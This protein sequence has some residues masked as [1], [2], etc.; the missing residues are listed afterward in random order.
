MSMTHWE[1]CWRSGGYS[2]YDCA[3]AQAERLQRQLKA[4][5]TLLRAEA[6]AH[7]SER[8]AL[9]QQVIR[10]QEAWKQAAYDPSL[11]YEGSHD[12]D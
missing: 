2:H 1:G 4:T 8:L 12:A 6:E 9:Q 11:L 3:V 7:S 10:L 5:E